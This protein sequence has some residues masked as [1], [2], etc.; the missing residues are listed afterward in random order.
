MRR[1]RVQSSQLR[2]GERKSL[3][4]AMLSSNFKEGQAG[5]N[6]RLDTIPSNIM[7]KILPYFYGADIELSHD[8]L[9]DVL[10]VADMWMLDDLKKIC[11]EQFPSI[12]TQENALQ[13]REI[14]LVYCCPVE[15]VSFGEKKFFNGFDGCLL[16]DAQF[17]Q[18]SHDLLIRCF[19]G[20]LC[21]IT[22]EVDVIMAIYRW[23]TFDVEYRRKYL[24]NLLKCC[25]CHDAQTE[26]DCLLREIESRAPQIAKSDQF[27][28]FVSLIPSKDKSQK[29][30]L[31]RCRSEKTQDG[32]IFAFVKEKTLYFVHC[33]ICGMHDEV[34]F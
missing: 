22:D 17:L 14:A 12:V 13:M 9:L 29:F 3:F 34:E 21:K 4:S 23:Y 11:Q 10:R 25:I 28:S 7:E 27:R 20:Y 15:V 6:L 24:K 16:T 19:V 30:A 32:M 2:A 5:H 1:P 31:A 18:V 8:D 33:N 26:E